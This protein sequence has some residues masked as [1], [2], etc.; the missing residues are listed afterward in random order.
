MRHF[1]GSASRLARVAV[2]LTAVIAVFVPAAAVHAA[3]PPPGTGK[4]PAG[5]GIN[6]P[7]AYANPSC[8]KA[9]GK[10]GI[11]GL[12]TVDA[13]P[14]CLP[15][16]KGGDNGGATY[17]GVTKDA[18][19]VV[20]LVPNAQQSA[21]LGPRSAPTNY[22]TG[23]PGTVP[24]A[25]AD[26][27]AAYEHAF[28][29]KYTAGRDIQVEYM[30]SGGDDEAAQRADAVTVLG[31]KPFVVLD[32]AGSLFVFDAQIANAKTPVFSLYTTVEQ[33]VKQAPYHWGQQDNSAAMING[34]EF[35]GKQVAG[36]KAE[37]AGDAAMHNQTRTLG[38][39]YSDAIE[40]SYFTDTLAKY[41]VK[42]GPDVTF[43]YSGGT[44]QTGDT[45]VAQ[46]Q[47]PVAIA[48]MKAGG[49]TTVL[50][51]AD[52][53]MVTA[54][55]S[56]ATA[57]DY[58]PEW[59]YLGSGNIDFPLLARTYDQSQWAHAFGLSNVW[60]GSPVATTTTPTAVQWYWGNQGTFGINPANSISWLMSGIMYAGPKLTPQ[61]LKQG[62]FSIPAGGG[63]AAVNPALRNQGVRFGYG[64]T[65]N[66]PYE[67][68]MRGNKDFAATYWD[69]ATVG[70]PTLS[71]PGGQGANMYLNN[72][73]RYYAGTWPTKPLTF[74]D[75]SKA[76]SQ[77]DAPAQP[78]PVL[79]CTGC[80]SQTGQGT[81]GATTS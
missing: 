44:S 63:S 30:T 52:P 47:A 16:W 43:S 80:P 70:P 42:V 27:L 26:T 45:A 74:F 14:V 81:P 37:Y 21:A 77:F 56:Q 46:T 15:E 32:L 55:T 1:E 34:G 66:L 24:D 3:E 6:T 20:A 35:V 62:W 51:L 53:A 68:Y 50:L 58:H 79:P 78:A 65:N 48:K 13:G 23:Q 2:V 8:N 22:A 41:H 60:P 33:S 4:P 57:Q 39:V 54:L 72:A 31:K 29:G 61:T 40:P 11:M 49:V 17:Q 64:H 69:P 10:Y 7:A 75:K 12:V 71:F 28:G 67:E 9:G 19:K 59:V 76:I 18:V 5:S 25:L 73:E 38:L 36:K